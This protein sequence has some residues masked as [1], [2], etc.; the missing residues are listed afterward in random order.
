MLQTERA[1][2]RIICFPR[3]PPPNLQIHHRVNDGVVTVDAPGSHQLSRRIVKLF[4]TFGRA[5]SAFSILWI[6]CQ[7][8][9]IDRRVIVEKARVVVLSHLF[10]EQSRIPKL[11]P[12]A[13]AL[14]FGFSVK[15]P[16]LGHPE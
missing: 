2:L 12:T 4:Q 9:T 13:P 14:V 10:A 3:R 11:S 1:P 5:Q 6:L 15:L 8:V 7:P 16:E